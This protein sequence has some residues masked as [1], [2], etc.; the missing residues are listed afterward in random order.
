M[1]YIGIED[2]AANAFIEMI[3]KS[4]NQPKKTYCVTL[5]ELEAYGRK[6]VQY[7]EQRGEK[8]VLMLSRDNTDAFFRDYLDFFEESEVYRKL[9]ISLKYEKKVEDLIHRFR[10]Y[11]QLDVLQAFINVGW[12]A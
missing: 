6:I 10:G 1:F 9:E 12:N 2:L 11:L 5:T 3:K 7:L 4:A 8:A